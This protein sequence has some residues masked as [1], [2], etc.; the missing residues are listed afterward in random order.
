M[1]SDVV[2]VVGNFGLQVRQSSFGC[3]S[4]RKCSGSRTQ[5]PAGAAAVCQVAAGKGV[6]VAVC[7]AV[8]AA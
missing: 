1:F 7:V 6:N 5:M 2:P 3:Y 8:C 4:V